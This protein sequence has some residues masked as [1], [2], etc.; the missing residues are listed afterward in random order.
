MSSG[1]SGMKNTFFFFN[2]VYRCATT[3]GQSP[4]QGG[5]KY[6]LSLREYSRNLY[7]SSWIDRIKCGDV[8]LIKLPN[9][10]RTFGLLGKVIEV[11]VGYDNIIRSVKVKQSNG[12]VAHHSICNLFPMELSITHPGVSQ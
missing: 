10:P 12:K 5:G 1:D 4:F 3:H 9:K 6:L 8:V 7:Q 2:T 11:V